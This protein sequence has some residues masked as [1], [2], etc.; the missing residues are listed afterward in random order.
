MTEPRS[1][2]LTADALARGIRRAYIKEHA[3][4]AAAESRCIRRAVGAVAVNAE[5]FII[6]ASCNFIKPGGDA[7]ERCP[8][9]KDAVAPGADY[10]AEGQRCPAVHAEEGAIVIG[11]PATAKVYVT[12]EPCYRCADLMTRLGIEF[13]VV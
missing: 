11:G 3:Q 2:P 13:E 1:K 12:E 7:C 8:L 10:T 6:G 9:S 4:S 5:G